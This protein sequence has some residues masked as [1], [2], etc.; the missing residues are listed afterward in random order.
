[1]TKVVIAGAGTAGTAAA[2]EL[3]GK[4]EV[5]LLNGEEALPYY[6][7]R[8]EEV[9]EGKGRDRITM[10]PSSWYEE[11]G[12]KLLSAKLSSID[13]EGKT[14]TLSDGAVLSY[15]KLVLAL[16]SRARMFQIPGRS[17][18]MTA[19]RTMADAEKLRE[20]LLEGPGSLVVI[21]GGLL[22]L[23]AAFSVA[24]SF[25]VKVTVLESAGHLLPRQ[26]DEE[27]SHYLE[28][29]LAEAGVEVRTGVSAV[30]G[31]EDSLSLSSGEVVPAGLVCFSIG[32]I[33]ETAAAL[34]A[35][36]ETGRGIVVDSRMRTSDED[37]YAAGDCAEHNGICSGLTAPARA[38]G[39]TAARGIL[40][41]DSVYVPSSS[42]TTL[43][44]AGVD[45]ISMGDISGSAH[46][47]EW[48]GG[49]IVKFVRDGVIRGIILID[50]KKSQKQA[51]ALL[52]SAC[53]E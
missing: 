20:K 43:K 36:L 10:R 18:N 6:R 22:G 34:D 12:I 13:R 9:V 15:D 51:A 47:E 45:I 26:L 8:L 24:R 3:A 31:T 32:V 17:G 53:G 28:R 11:K 14:V 39:I 44:V 16:G 4:A 42:V 5:Y 46:E 48:N 50:N 7:M 33:P 19:L 38:M 49:R 21:G 37:I 23:E 41:E 29:K 35:G 40:G 25:P 2:A 52:G 1:M 27:R 30:S